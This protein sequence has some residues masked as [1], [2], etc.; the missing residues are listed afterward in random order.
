[1]KKEIEF[2]GKKYL[3]NKPTRLDNAEADIER[4]IVF[5][6]CLKRNL[7]LSANIAEELKKANIWDD[8]KQAK[9][10]DLTSNLQFKIKKLNLGNMK[11]SEAKDL[12]I[13][14]SD[15]RMEV[16]KIL[17]DRNKYESNTA[18]SHANN[19]RFD[20][21][22]QRCC[23]DESG[24]PVWKTLQEYREDS[25]DLSFHLSDAL[26]GYI[27]DINDDY[28]RELPENKFLIKYKLVDQ[29]LNFI[30]RQGH[31]VDKDGRLIDD[32]GRFIKYGSDGKPVYVNKDG[33]EINEDGTPTNFMPFLDDD[34]NPILDTNE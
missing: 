27:Y 11:L 22:V 31:K 14:I 21:L 5:Q 7:P 33:E 23:K 15:L 16:H 24:E 1:M 25:T 34:G 3:I 2:Q 26:A 13:E 4:S 19:A 17:A 9:Y 10:E 30:N 32:N 18:D 28:V 8:A 29:E 20:V 12:A 6:E